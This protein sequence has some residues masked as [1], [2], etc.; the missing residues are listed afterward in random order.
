MIKANKM[1]AILHLRVSTKDQGETFESQEVVCKIVAISKGC[2]EDQ[3][4]V[5][6]EKISGRIEDSKFF[7]QN[8]DYIKSHPGDI[9]YYIIKSIDRFTRAGG[10]V[11]EAMKKELAENYWYIPIFDHNMKPLFPYEEYLQLK[12]KKPEN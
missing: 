12:Q 9:R 3:I 6:K 8:R 11:Y 7:N 10:A 2:P 5:R 4:I 1:G